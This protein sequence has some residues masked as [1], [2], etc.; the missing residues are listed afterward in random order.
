MLRIPI[1]AI[2]F[3]LSCR[4]LSQGVGI[5]NPTPHAS[6]LLD[7]TS[8]GKGLLLPRM[9]TGQRDAIAA[10]ATSLLIFNTTNARYEYFDGLTWVP[11]VLSGS[12]LDLAYDF[13]GA[14]AG[15]TITADAGAVTIAG[16]DGLLSTGVLNTGAT[17]P[18]G[19]GAR[20]IWNPR[21]AAFRAGQVVGTQWNEASVGVSSSAFGE[22]TTASGTGSTA[23]G[24]GTVA[25]GNYATAGGSG[26]IAS[27]T[28]AS[29]LGYQAA[30]TGDYAHATGCVI[31][32]PSFAEAAV[33]IFNS[34]YVP[35]STTTWNAADRIFSVGNGTSSG[36]RSNALTI[37]K[38]GNSGF[39]TALPQA[40]LHVVGSIRM[41]DGNQAAGHV[42]VSDANGTA[43]W[44]SAASVASGTLDQAYDSG[45]PGIGRTITADAGAVTIAGTDGLVSTG[46]NTNTGALAPSGAGL[47]MVWNPSKG[48]FRAGRVGGAQWDPANIGLYSSAWGENTLASGAYATAWGWTNSASDNYAT[49]WGELNTA[50]GEYATVWGEDNTAQGL[51]STVWGS[52]NSATGE[53]ATMWGREN[54]ASQLRSTAWGQSNTADATDATAWGTGNTAQGEQATAWGANNTASGQHATAWGNSTDATGIRSTAWGE[55][56]QASG[57]NATAWGLNAMATGNTGA[58]AFGSSTTASNDQATAWGS[59]SSANG[60]FSTAWGANAVAQGDGSTAWG[61]GAEA[62]ADFT[63]AWGSGSAAGNGATAWG[64]AS[65]AS[66]S[67]ATAWGSA[68]EASATEATAWGS[69]T[70][71]SGMGATTWGTENQASGTF[72]TAW[73]QFNNAT[74]ER[75]TSWGFSNNALSYGETV[76]GIGSTAY[77]LSANGATQF[78]TANAADRIL[79]VGNAVDANSNNLVDAAERSDALVI[80]K[81]GNTGL[82]VSAPAVRL[83]V[84]GRSLFH[85]GFSADN[86]ALLY[87]NNTDYMFIGPQSGSSANG[88]AIAL[89]GSTNASAG[90][91]SG[92][93]VNVPNGRVRFTQTNGQFEFRSNS[94]SGYQASMELNDAGLQIGHNSASRAIS[95]NNGNGERLRITTV[96]NNLTAGGSWGVLSDRRVKSDIRAIQYGLKEVLAIQPVRYFHHDTRGFDYSPGDTTSVGKQDIGFIAQDLFKVVPEVVVRPTDENTGLWAVTYERLVPVLVK[97]IQEQQLEI[98]ALR[99]LVEGMR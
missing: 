30:A 64:S 2:A 13:G 86:A 83:H 43:S 72:T 60:A 7:L 76:L 26:A 96:G 98:E 18:A 70:I 32:A 54:T 69:A 80:L 75:S 5:N 42:L 47:R 79:S 63:T 71:A 77:T 10:P 90:N 11:L 12:T 20:L 45:G 29:A 62:N 61:N 1:I 15:A 51:R 4:A 99:E 34:T 3:L 48:A 36:S 91:A 58:T 24:G 74:G 95:F 89:F 6:A 35:A 73:G 94:T 81:N 33:G 21:K 8:T 93:D 57:G 85:N 92:M 50:S 39:G 55:G 56:T 52:L 84:A 27:G 23:W 68:T 41:V 25:S 46:T 88:A 67:Q 14:G 49:A 97:A 82:G 44:A 66:G 31:T 87:R 78:R 37:L 22:H 16:T 28:F 38:N 40:R 19:A 9:T 17:I 65:E 59:G 53:S